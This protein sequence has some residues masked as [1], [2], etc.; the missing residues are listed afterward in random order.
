MRHHHE[1][2]RM[3]LRLKRAPG[4]ETEKYRGALTLTLSS[5]PEARTVLLERTL[6]DCSFSSGKREP[7]VD[8]PSGCPSTAGCSAGDSVGSHLTGPLQESGREGPSGLHLWGLIQMEK[9]PGLT[10]TSLQVWQTAFLL[11]AVPDPRSQP[12]V[13]PICKAEPVADPTL[14]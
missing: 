3:R 9:G 14:R 12:A 13:L 5:L 11:A 1:N 7:K 2:L 6:Q 8:V 4:P 10:A